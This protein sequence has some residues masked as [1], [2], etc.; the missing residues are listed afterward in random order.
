MLRRD[1]REQRELH[2]VPLAVEHPVEVLAAVRVVRREGDEAAFREPGREVVVGRVVALDHVFG[3]AVPAVLADHDRPLLALLDPLGHQQHAP[4]EDVGIDVEHD[5]VA[6]P[7]RRVVDLARARVGRQ[8]RVGDAAE[9]LLGRTLRSGATSRAKTSADCSA[10]RDMRNRSPRGARVLI[11]VVR[12][13]KEASRVLAA[14]PDEALDVAF[15][16]LDLPPLAI[17]RGET[18]APV[19]RCRLVRLLPGGDA[20]EGHEVADGR[21]PEEVADRPGVLADEVTLLEALGE[22]GVDPLPLRDDIGRRRRAELAGRGPS[23]PTLRHGRRARDARPLAVLDDEPARGDQGRDLGVA[24]LVQQAPDVAIDRLGPDA[25]PGAEVAADQRRVD[26]RVRGRGVEGDQAALAVAGHADLGPRPRPEPEPI[27]RGQDLLDLVA[28][29]VPAHVVRLPVDPLA[30]R[31]VRHRDPRVPG[32]F[33]PAADQG[34]DHDAEAARRQAPGELRSGRDAG[35]QARQ[36]LGRLVRVRQRRRRGPR[37]SPSAPAGGPRRGRPRG[38]ASGPGRPGR[39]RT[40]PP[41]PGR[42]RRRTAPSPRAG[43]GRRRR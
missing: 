35:G 13:R 25:L 24:E 14:L 1:E 31:L 20:E 37:P 22:E 10:T 41:A 4:G 7:L 3:Q 42:R 17:V 15:Q 21:R 18:P 27:H 38:P 30:M 2:R 6:G 29:D 23:A 11:S 32:G 39:R 12:S 19:G 28:D 33:D 26:P 5:L 40:R 34:R 16:L 9:D 36:L 43:A 8:D